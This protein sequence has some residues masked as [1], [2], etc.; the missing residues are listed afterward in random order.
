[1]LIPESLLANFLSFRF[2][3]F[4]V[5]D[6]R[7]YKTYQEIKSFEESCLDKFRYSKLTIL[8]GTVEEEVAK[9]SDR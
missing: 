7:T 8:R 9:I 2:I 1:M 5:D 4:T 6:E 3:L